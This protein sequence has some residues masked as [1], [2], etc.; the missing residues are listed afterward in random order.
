MWLWYDWRAAA[1]VNEHGHVLDE[2]IWSSEYPLP[3]VKERL[4]MV[5]RLQLTPEATSLHERFPEA[6]LVR[7][8]EGDIPS[9]PIPELSDA[10]VQIA[11]QA[12]IELTRE[13]VLEAGADQDRRLEHLVRASDELR[14]THITMEARIIEWSGLFFP[15]T[16][17]RDRAQLVRLL[18]SSETPETFAQAVEQPSLGIVSQ[19]EWESIRSWAANT[20]SIH[21][22]LEQLDDVIRDVSLDYVP[23][24]SLLI[25]PLL[26]ARLVVEAHGRARLARL[27]SGTIQVLGAEKAFFSHLKTGTP[28]PKHGHIF[29]HPWISR[30][31]RWV[32]GKIARMLAGKISIAAKLDAFNGQS[33]TPSFVQMVE[34]KVESIKSAHPQPP[35]RR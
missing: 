10:A 32:R 20:S 9:F 22:R 6:K 17:A 16:D 34:E 27:P 21:Q 2:V 11:D 5:Q 23:S 28:P 4:R 24:L 18:A 13:G 35:K 19:A 14:A 31:P 33:L 26:S 7:T 12:M 25:G 1:I 3:A 8:G 15:Y 29:M 30:S